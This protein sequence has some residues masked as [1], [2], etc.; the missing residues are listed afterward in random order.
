VKQHF[1]RSKGGGNVLCHFYWLNGIH[2]HQPPDYARAEKIRNN[3]FRHNGKRET[4]K[5]KLE[6]AHYHRH[7][8]EHEKKKR[9]KKKGG[10]TLS[11]IK[12]PRKG[13]GENIISLPFSLS[14]FA[15]KEERGRSRRNMA[16]EGGKKLCSYRAYREEKGKYSLLAL[17]ISL[18]ISFRATIGEERSGSLLY[19]LI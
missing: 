8:D 11:P 15:A 6:R 18:P 1:L 14:L 17:R 19:S 5:S 12:M 16:E 4:T 13:K 10:L 3:L 2:L 7:V 9:K